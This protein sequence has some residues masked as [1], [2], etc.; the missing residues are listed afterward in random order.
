MHRFL[1]P[2]S[3]FGTNVFNIC[4]MLVLWL[5]SNFPESPSEFEQKYNKQPIVCVNGSVDTLLLFGHLASEAG[6]GTGG[7]LI[8]LL[9]TASDRTR[10]HLGAQLRLP[11][12]RRTLIHFK[13]LLQPFVFTSSSGEWTKQS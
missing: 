4:P 7:V 13:R 3:C 8:G 1:G 10:A 5:C 9:P 11:Y 2:W 6:K 12:T